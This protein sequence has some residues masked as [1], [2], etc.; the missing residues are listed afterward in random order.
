MPRP[1]GRALLNSATF[2]PLN[3][4]TIQLGRTSGGGF[5]RAGSFTWSLDLKT[6]PSF[7]EFKLMAGQ[8]N[9]IPVYQE[10]LADTETPVSAYLKIRDK[11]FSYL[12]E[13]A[14]GGKR[15]G[16]YSFIGYKPFLIAVSRDQEME[17]L[18]RNEKKILEDVG[19]P[20]H[21][22]RDLIEKFKPVTIQDL[23]PF[24]GGLVGYFNYD[25]VRRWECR[26]RI[27]PEDRKMPESQFTFSRR[28]IIFDHLTHQIRVVAFAYL[29]ENEDLK[30]V[31]DLASQEVD[32]TIGELQRPLSPVSEAD[33][34]SLSDL[35]ANFNREDFEKAVDKAKEL[36]E[37]A[38]ETVKEA[39]SEAWE[40][41]EGL[42]EAVADKVGDAA[43]KAWDK[44]EDVG[45][46]VAEKAEDLKDKVMGGA[47]KVADASEEVTEDLTEASKQVMDDSAES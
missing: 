7:S 26:P 27:S 25:L 17:I 35:E 6:K 38:T 3:S 8:G 30:E 4:A 15:W 32:E 14:D 33:T 2:T 13:S 20:L 44:V 23:S 5:N 24:Q 34:F 46:A 45:E 43:G 22:L 42:G 40:K 29:R 19:N 21:V 1:E 9:L 16:R 39:G 28:L 47:D 31:Y 36:G 18:E 10:F 37:T 41:A 11:S 12:L